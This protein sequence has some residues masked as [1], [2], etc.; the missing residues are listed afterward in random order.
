MSTVAGGAASGMR[1]DAR[2]AAR[3]GDDLWDQTASNDAG[4]D[5]RGL[6]PSAYSAIF[7]HSLDGVMFTAPDGRILA[8]NDAACALLGMREDEILAAGRDGVM[9]PSDPGWTDALNQ[10]RREGQAR[11]MLRMRRGDGS[12][13]LA[14]VASVIFEV[15][16]EKRACVVV[17]DASDHTP[18]SNR[19]VPPTP[20][21]APLR[22]V[23]SPRERVVMTYL[24]TR[25]TY[26]EIAAELFIST[27]T[28]KTHVKAIYRKLDAT[29]RA[30]AVARAR[31]LGRVG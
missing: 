27:N 29:S 15:G 31:A 9:D 18:V 28:L 17:R 26:R 7:E 20:L 12:V 24:G 5:R 21:L 16:E 30:D 14:D 11:A 3:L 4:I 6:G 22:E 23:L 1:T 19:Q 8:A 25:M 13:F 2:G 10:R